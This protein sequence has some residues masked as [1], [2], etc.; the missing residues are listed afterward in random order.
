VVALCVGSVLAVVALAVVAGVALGGGGSAPPKRPLAQA[1]RDA[2]TA[3]AVQGVSARVKFT[4]NLFGSATTDT[5]SA[6]LTGGSGRLWASDGKLRLELQS[7]NG[8]AQVVVANGRGFVYDG[9]S[10]TAYTFALDTGSGPHKARAASHAAPT[11]SQIVSRVAE[12]RGHASISQPAPGVIA[13]EPA[14]SVRVTPRARG[15]LLGAAEVAWD[16]AGGVPLRLAVYARGA[17]KPALELVATDINFSPVDSSVFA[18]RPP[19]GAKVVDLTGGGSSRG[20]DSRS[21]FVVNRPGAL[22]GRARRAVKRLG[23]GG[24][25]VL[26][27]KGLDTIAVLEHAAKPGNSG[28]APQRQG[29]DGQPLELPSVTI[30]GANAT[31]LGTALGGVIRFERGGVAYTVAGSQPLAVLETAARGL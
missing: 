2:V 4:S 9:P 15:G 20:S 28:Q 8:D 27:G 22:A 29:H 13:G 26:Y 11:L 10:D 1:I 25:I 23:D 6:L 7:D 5:S 30:N 24:A 17:S 31:A 14:Y 18:L 3:P 12:A 16:A 19:A 21:S